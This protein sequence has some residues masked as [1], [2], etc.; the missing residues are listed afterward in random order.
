MRI[1][2]GDLKAF[3]KAPPPLPPV[4]E[5]R[6]SVAEEV[7]LLALDAPG[8]AAGQAAKLAGRAYPDGPRDHDEAVRALRERGL[9][10]EDRA[11]K[12]T[13]EALLQRRKDRVLAIVRRAATPAGADAELVVLL[14]LAQALPLE[15]ADDRLRARTRL[16]SIHQAQSAPP[17]A[18]A[19]ADEH[20][21][22][23]G[24]ADAVLPRDSGLKDAKFD[25]GSSIGGSSGLGF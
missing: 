5:P 20:D 2:R 15:N 1:S 9:V 24:F 21:T 12:A 7:T 17:A 22:A 4:L 18:A 10:T 3:S 13:S 25:P 14:A 11:P 6:L 19:L 8:R 23:E 16:Q